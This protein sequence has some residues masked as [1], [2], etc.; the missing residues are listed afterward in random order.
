MMMD[1]DPAN[2]VDD[3]DAMWGIQDK[4]PAVGD[5][6]AEDLNAGRQTGGLPNAFQ[7]QSGAAITISSPST[8]AGSGF[9][10][11]MKLRR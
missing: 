3:D 11:T 10:K 8:I 1:N 4:W 5:G 6:D 9:T 2:S 7:I